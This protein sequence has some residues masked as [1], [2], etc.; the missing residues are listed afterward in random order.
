M[1]VG[2]TAHPNLGSFDRWIVRIAF[3]MIDPL[4]WWMGV[5]QHLLKLSG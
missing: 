5:R 1:S 3:G 4:H 2:P